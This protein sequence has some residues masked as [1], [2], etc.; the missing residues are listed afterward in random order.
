M[1]TGDILSHLHES[2]LNE[3]DKRCEDILAQIQSK[4]DEVLSQ[5]E[6]RALIEAFKTIQEKVFAIKQDYAKR[7]SGQ[8]AEYR[9]QVIKKRTQIMQ[10]VFEKVREQLDAYTQTDEYRTALV[11]EIRQ[12]ASAYPGEHASVGVSAADMK[13]VGA[14]IGTDI[15]VHENADIDIGGFTFSVQGRNILI[16]CTLDMRAGEQREYFESM[17]GLTIS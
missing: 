10:D 13:F 11:S 9:K 14:Q 15:E 16:D 1:A 7:L 17:S 6:E 4:R 8:T 2:V 12:T 5:A 3:A